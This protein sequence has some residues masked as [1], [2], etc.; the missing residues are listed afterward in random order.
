MPPIHFNDIQYTIHS[1]DIHF[2]EY[3]INI[4]VFKVMNFFDKEAVHCYAL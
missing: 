3:T 4:K 2:K 1:N